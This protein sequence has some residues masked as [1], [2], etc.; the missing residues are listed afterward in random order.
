[1][2]QLGRFRID[3][4]ETG[5]FGLDGGAMF[6]V[7]PKPLWEKAYHPADPANRIPMAARAL[8][9]RWEEHAVMVDTG[10]GIKMPQKQRQ[11]YAL[12]TSQYSLEESLRQVGL[13]PED[14]TAVI[15]THLHFD[16][17][18][19]ST[20]LDSAGA[21][22]PTFPK[23]R[24]YVQRDHLRWA[25]QPTEKDRASFLAEDFEPLIAE[26]VLEVLDG[27]G[28]LFPGIRL[29]LVHGHTQAMQLVL[30][31]DAG[32]HLLFC[33]DLCPTAAHVAYPY[34]MA[35]DNFPL[36]T[37]EEKKRILPQAYEEGWILCFEHDAFVQA[38]RLQPTTK[39]FTIGESLTITSYETAPAPTMD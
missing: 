29:L 14:I 9:L 4:I 34:I 11:I 28:E 33:A 18:G 27:E 8:L 23:A 12:D 36:T 16:H 37:L 38:A 15:L 3:T 25:R 13:C 32:Q 2:L 35:Y 31:S 17:A 30:V 20:R 24:Y 22:V 26:G 5:R 6:G 19:G 1:M 39:G 21:V 10:N 7:V